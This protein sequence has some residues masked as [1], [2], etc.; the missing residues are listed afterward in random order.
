MWTFMSIQYNYQVFQQL[1]L[2]N[3]FHLKLDELQ[4]NI[5]FHEPFLLFS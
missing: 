2:D 5:Q 4:I 3:N 1:L